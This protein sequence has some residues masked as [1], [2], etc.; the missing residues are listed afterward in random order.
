MSCLALRSYSAMRSVL[1]DQHPTGS[2]GSN[3]AYHQRAPADRRCLVLEVNL[4]NAD[5]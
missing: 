1:F 5:Q 3:Q 2:W 4:E